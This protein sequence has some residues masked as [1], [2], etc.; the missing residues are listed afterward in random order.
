[1]KEK[2]ERKRWGLIL[3]LVIIMIG[4]SFSVFFY[5]G[6][7]QN[8]IVKYN[9]IKFVSSSNQGP[10]IAKVNG[11]EATFSFLPTEVET[12]NVNGDIEKLNGKF[13]IDVTSDVNSTYK[14]A[15]ALAHHQMTLTLAPYNVFIRQGF[16]TNSTFNVPIIECDDAT[17]NVPVV[18]FVYGNS[19]SISL[20]NDCILVKASTDADFIKIKDRLLYGILGVIK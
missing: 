20:E 3:F 19:T 13:E 12:I 5:G 6:S 18:Y 9:G 10:W 2:K 1:M 14:E 7:P 4:T 8:E 16:T 11:K 17:S 15:I